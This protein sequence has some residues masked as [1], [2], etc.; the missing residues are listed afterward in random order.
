MQSAEL[1][2]RICAAPDSDFGSVFTDLTEARWGE[3]VELATDKRAAPLLDR[4]IQHAK[5]AH[6]V[7]TECSAMIADQLRL[8]TMSAFGHLIALTQAVEFLKAHDITPIALKGARLAFADYPEGRLRPLR[9]LDLLVPAEI[10]EHTQQLMIDSGVYEV[11]SWADHYGI[12]FGHQLP[13][14]LDTHRGISF[15]IHHRL[16]ARGWPQEPQLVQRMH[17]EAE[18][19]T[20]SGV[21]I[22]VPSM[23]AN[24][25]HLVEHATLHHMFENGPL[26][27]ADLHFAAKTGKVDWPALI[28]EAN[29]LGLERSLQLVAALALKYGATWVP[30]ALA[31]TCGNM[32]DHIDVA[33]EAILRDEDDAEHHKFLRNLSMR[34]GRQSG[35]RAAIRAALTPNPLRLAGML[36]VQGN[37][38]IRWLA[39]PAWLVQRGAAYLAAR[40]VKTITKS[41][42]REVATLNWLKQG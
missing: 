30:A 23:H 11:A 13:E 10:A 20:L 1:L 16:N 14:L 33:E 25:L 3:L 4:S 38:P 31:E 34:K 26:I 9:D 27:L 17:D 32:A 7:P 22:R 8:H 21:P 28:A 39:Y 36:Q 2:M 5:S 42:M 29:A 15:E 18:T 40:R 41:T 12:E 37:N 6:L 24:F 35:W 19:I